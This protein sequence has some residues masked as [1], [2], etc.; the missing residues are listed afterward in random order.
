MT[1]FVVLSFAVT[2]LGMALGRVPGLR[3]DRAGIAM[4]VAVVLVAAGA[5]PVDAVGNAIHFPTLLLLGGLMILSARVGAS[6]FYNAAAAW[7]AGQ[8]G[9]PLR[10][11]ALTVAIGGILSALLVNDIVVFAM[12]PLLC[13]GLQARNLDPRPFLFGLAAASNAGSAAT[14]I[15]NPQNIL[16]GQAGQ[17]GFWSYILDAAVP[18]LAGLVVSFACIAFVWRSSLTAPAGDAPLTK[19]AFDRR[20]VGFCG[21]ALAVLLA[22]FATSLPREVSALLVAACLIV[23]RVLPTRQ[24]LDE[25]DL[26]LLILFAA[27]FVVNDALARTGVPEEAVRALETHGLLPDR[28]SLLAPIALVLSNTIGNVPAVVMILKVWQGIPQGTLVGLAIL[29][30]LAGNLFL[31]GSLANLIVAERASAQGLRLTFRDHAKAG[32]PI[33]LFSMLLAGFW[34]WM[35]GYMPL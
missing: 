15:G 6:G 33:T 13:A 3:V 12:T 19:V 17:I 1:Q 30:T 28:V 5:V 27:L 23:S 21:V 31:V 22:L 4:I 14:L 24:L 34:L 2:Y 18:S 9:R 10:L 7:I 29:S 11:L 26:P 35:G 8:A 16:I 20:Q 25:I 32:V